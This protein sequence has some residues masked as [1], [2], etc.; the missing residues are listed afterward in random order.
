LLANTP[1]AKHLLDITSTMLGCAKAGSLNF[2][3][4]TAALTRRMNAEMMRL[5]RAAKVAADDAE[6]SERLGYDGRLRGVGASGGG[7]AGPGGAGGALGGAGGLL[8]E[9]PDAALERAEALGKRR[10]KKRRKVA[11][12]KDMERRIQQQV[13]RERARKG[14]CGAAC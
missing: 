2:R 4:K 14:A 6:R 3:G 10:Y 1:Q 11:L 12:P 7:L 8:E 5:Q 9:G 13:R